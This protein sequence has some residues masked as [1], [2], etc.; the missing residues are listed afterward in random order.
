MFKPDPKPEPRPKKEKKRIRQ[1]SAKRKVKNDEYK[2][3][4]DQYL[5]ENFKCEKCLYAESIEVHHQ[6][7]KVGG[8][9]IPLLI[10]T[11]YFM[12]VCRD[13]HVWIELHPLE[14]LKMGWSLKRLDK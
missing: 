11:A 4:R 2:I 7:G 10:D 5:L 9:P 14:S 1:V 13:C 12:A 6:C 8:H 3:I